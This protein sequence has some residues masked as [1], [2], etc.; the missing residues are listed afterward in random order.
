MSSLTND[1]PTDGLPDYVIGNPIDLPTGTS[2][3]IVTFYGPPVAREIS[4]DGDPLS[5]EPL[6]EAGWS[7]YR[8]A[9]DIAGRRNRRVPARLRPPE[10]RRRCVRS[11]RRS[12]SSHCGD[13]SSSSLRLCRSHR[14]AVRCSIGRRTDDEED[15]S[16]TRRNRDDGPRRRWRRERER[17]PAQRRCERHR[18]TQHRRAPVARST[19]RRTARPANR[20][21]S[22]SNRRPRRPSA[23]RTAR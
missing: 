16:G 14:V 9:I 22:P 6:T 19:S 11:T 2:R 13:R 21:R 3:L 5:V 7:G 8:T 15:C 17:L 10:R 1:A 12:S 18:L 4:L 23:A 20:S